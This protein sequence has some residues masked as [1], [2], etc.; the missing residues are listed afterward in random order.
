M[1]IHDVH[2]ESFLLSLFGRKM[3]FIYFEIEVRLEFM[4]KNIHWQEE[5]DVLICLVDQ[6]VDLN[7]V[8]LVI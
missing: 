7:V 5:V 8:D 6:F 2:D 3:K 1:V 4:P